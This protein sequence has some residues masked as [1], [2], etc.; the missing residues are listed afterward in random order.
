MKDEE[1]DTEPV[2]P[3]LESVQ[4]AALAARAESIATRKAV[5]TFASSLL[6]LHA[7]VVKLEQRRPRGARAR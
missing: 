3:S 4:R 6:E 1:A 5:E 2:P 7:R